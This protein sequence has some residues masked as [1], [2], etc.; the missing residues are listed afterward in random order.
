MAELRRRTERQPGGADIPVGC[1]AVSK[2]RP[3]GSAAG[4]GN[5]LL[6]Q[7]RGGRLGRPR[8]GVQKEKRAV[9]VVDLLK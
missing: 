3:V 6:G 7:S 8:S 5:P 2:R 4:R 9:L 1:R